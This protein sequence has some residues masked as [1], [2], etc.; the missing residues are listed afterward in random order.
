MV[1]CGC[2]FVSSI[3]T[4]S[5]SIE[6]AE[7]N[8]VV[9]SLLC[10]CICE[11]GACKCYCCTGNIFLCN[12]NIYVILIN[13]VVVIICRCELSFKCS[14]SFACLITNRCVCIYPS[15]VSVSIIILRKFR[16][17]SRKCVT[18][19]CINGYSRLINVC[20]IDYNV[21]NYR[22]CIIVM[23]LF[24]RDSNIA[25]ICYIFYYAYT[26][27]ECLLGMRQRSTDKSFKVECAICVSLCEGISTI[28]VL[29]KVILACCIDCDN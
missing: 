2:S 4:I 15:P 14:C 18:V 9:L 10:A 23:R 11:S 7:T 13:T 29:Y 3:V 12:L 5:E 8:C 24:S 19:S 16:L 20:L 28:I 25:A 26:V 21:N 22:Y 27:R 6:S 1:T 17:N